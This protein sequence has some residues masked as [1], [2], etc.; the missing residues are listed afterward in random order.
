[1][2]L[3]PPVLSP[4][5]VLT[6]LGKLGL[7]GGHVYGVLQAFFGLFFSSLDGRENR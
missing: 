1:M 6:M 5:K 7:K 4:P 3:L 2:P